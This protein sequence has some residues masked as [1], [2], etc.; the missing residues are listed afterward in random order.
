MRI[1]SLALLQPLHDLIAK[2]TP[3]GPSEEDLVKSAFKKILESGDTYNMAD[4]EEWLASKANGSSQ[5]IVDRLMNI[6]HYQ[7]SKYDASNKFRMLSGEN[8]CSCGGN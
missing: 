8:D 3:L 4:L 6:A 7:K 1:E 5:Q 2:S